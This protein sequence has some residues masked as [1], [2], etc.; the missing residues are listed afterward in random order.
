MYGNMLDIEKFSTKKYFRNTDKG[1]LACTRKFSKK[2]YPP[3]WVPPKMPNH[4]PE[5]QANK[6]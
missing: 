2:L 4:L 6:K 5:Y 1:L 3:K